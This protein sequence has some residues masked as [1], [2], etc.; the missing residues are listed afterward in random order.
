MSFLTQGGAN[1]DLCQAIH[2]N[3]AQFRFRGVVES[4]RTLG[5]Y[6]DNI[7]DM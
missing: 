2:Y 3:N 4:L 6:P 5:V 7:Y 1:L